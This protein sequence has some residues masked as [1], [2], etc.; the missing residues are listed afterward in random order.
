MG[1]LILA[2]RKIGGGREARACTAELGWER[3]ACVHRR[4][5]AGRVKREL[6]NA[7]REASDLFVSPRAR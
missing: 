3:S 6:R 2:V 1:V 7:A 4:L 5:R